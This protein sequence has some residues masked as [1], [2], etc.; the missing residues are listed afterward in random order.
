LS[1]AIKFT[2]RGH[3]K[4]KLSVTQQ[5]NDKVRLKFTVEDT[6]IG[7]ASDKLTKI[8]DSFEQAEEDTS[9]KYGGT[10]LGLTI[11]KKLVELKGGELTFSSQIGKG[12]VFNFSNWYTIVN[13]PEP[14][15]TEH[16]PNGGILQPFNDINVLVA[17]DNLV[18]QFI[19]SKMLT[20]WNVTFE[21]VDNGSKVI[22]K[23]RQQDYDI[24]LMDTNMPVMNGYQAAKIIRLDFE[25]PKRSIPIISLSAAALDHEQEEAISAG[26]NDVLSKPFQATELHSKIHK[27]L[28]TKNPA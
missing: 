26:M 19:V 16:K 4:L 7:I 13:K 8:F 2:D 15:T 14:K 11:V 18:N 21:I 9:N 10:G 22:D 24:I 12:S 5:H 1:N 17:E 3:V 25:E 27:L 23:L 6:G 28:K 20:D